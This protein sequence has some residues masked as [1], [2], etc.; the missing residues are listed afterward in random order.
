MRSDFKPSF[1]AHS[2][3]QA[4]PQLR[5]KKHRQ[6][7]CIIKSWTHHLRGLRDD[8]SNFLSV[9]RAKRIRA[10]ARLRYEQNEGLSVYKGFEIRKASRKNGSL[11]LKF[12]LNDW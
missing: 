10:C 8:V 6:I 12:G 5:I 3:F 1:Q 7:K 11:I 2:A 4:K 9:W